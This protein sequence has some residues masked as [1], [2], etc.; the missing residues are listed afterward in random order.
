M[1]DAK[2]SFA[3]ELIELGYRETLA[4]LTK[5]PAMN[6]C[7]DVG[8]TGASDPSCRRPLNAA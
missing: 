4:Y 1:N 2:A 3:E 6:A 8:R 7:E 5:G